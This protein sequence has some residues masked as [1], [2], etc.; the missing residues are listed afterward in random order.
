MLEKKVLM[1]MLAAC[2]GRLRVPHANQR[3]C[4]VE[5]SEIGAVQRVQISMATL[6]SR[7]AEQ[8]KVCQ[9]RLE[10]WAAR[11]PD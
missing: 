3:G 10:H 2:L 7:D 4:D 8:L 6:E 1:R 9:V 11:Q 5:I